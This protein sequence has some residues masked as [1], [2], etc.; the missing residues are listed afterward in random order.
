MRKPTI[1]IDIDDVVA[2]GTNALIDSINKQHNTTLT[3]SD[4]HNVGGDFNGYYERVW[5]AHGLAGVAKYDD[6]AKEMI[7]DQSHVPLLA[8]AEFAI[9]E[10]AKQFHVIFITAR[11]PEWEVAT[12]QWFS[13][14]LGSNEIEL[15]FA[16]NYHDTTALTKGELAVQLNAELLIDDN[17]KNCQS[18]L[19]N[20]LKAILFGNYGWQ[21]EAPTDMIRC[22]G[23]PAVLEYLG[24]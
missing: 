19:D 18:A 23:W 14:H 13:Q 7:A 11:P 5:N 8:D 15:Y 9:S 21:N 24:V 4:Y 2:E 22:E 10:L 12:R 16:G 1:A 6:V 17:I 20:N 3:P